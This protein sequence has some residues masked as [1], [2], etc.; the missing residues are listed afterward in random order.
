MNSADDAPTVDPRPYKGE[1]AG[2]ESPWV[3]LPTTEASTPGGSSKTVDVIICVHNAL[4]RVLSGLLS[5]IKNT[6]QPYNLILINDGSDQS[7]SSLLRCI[8]SQ[9]GSVLV[10]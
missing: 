4:E 5:V 2:A 3:T 8:S 1:P 7:T 10:E 6:R 9:H